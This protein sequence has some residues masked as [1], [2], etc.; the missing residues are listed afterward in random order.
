MEDVQDTPPMF[1]GTPY[2]GYVYEDTL[3]V[4]NTFTYRRP[5]SNGETFQHYKLAGPDVTVVYGTSLTILE[6]YIQTL[7]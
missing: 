3:A 7:T 6:T 1:I 2:Y 4:S 5:R